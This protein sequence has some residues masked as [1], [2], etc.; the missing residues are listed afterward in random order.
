LKKLKELDK[1]EMIHRVKDN[2]KWAGI[3]ILAWV[4]VGV[5]WLGYYTALKSK[6]FIAGFKES[7]KV[8]S[9]S[10]PDEPPNGG[11]ED[12]NRAYR[13][14]VETNGESIY[15]EKDKDEIDYGQNND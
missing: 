13:V 9:T 14:P 3:M 15:I 7:T 4:V 2:L 6:N 12:K 1:A 5:F 10:Q 11:G 8:A